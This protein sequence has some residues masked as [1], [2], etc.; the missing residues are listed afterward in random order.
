LKRDA[1]V[2]VEEIKKMFNTKGILE[3]RWSKRNWNFWLQKVTF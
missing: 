2:R 1:T 3:I